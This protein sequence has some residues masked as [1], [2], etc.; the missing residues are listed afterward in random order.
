MAHLAAFAF[1]VSLAFSGFM[2][3]A[4]FLDQPE[5][6]SNH[7][8]PIPTAGGIGIMAGFGAGMLAL[9]LF[10]PAYADQRLL[11]SL[12]ALGLGAGL[13][14]L[15]DDIYD[16]N[17]KWKFV[18]IILLAGA[19]VFAV[20]PPMTFPVIVGDGLAIPTWLGFAGAI[21]WIFVV[22]NGVNFMDGANGLMAGSMAIAFI[23]LCLIAVLVGA[24]SAAL[25][26]FIMA[27]ALFGFLPYN[28]GNQAKIFSGDVGS[29]LVGFMFASVSLLLV[30]EAPN[31]QLL[32]VGP[33]LFLPFLTDILLTMFLRANR[34]ENLFAP[35]STHLYQRLIRKG[36]TH[37]SI[38]ILYGLATYFMAVITIA[39]LWFGL[40]KSLFFLAIWVCV[41]SV[42]YLL[43]HKKLS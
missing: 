7:A 30:A 17:A 43:I 27:A 32:Y 13:L 29:L 40:I 19:C 8:R 23:A 11:G 26:S 2:I 15:F 22:T 41:F 12:T 1:L 14:G 28:A 39:G 10:Y 25:V 38:S 37:L 24:S 20:G 42:I 21:L 5:G 36:K 4:G 33:M 18:A 35:H 31:F 16:V 6:R 34:H 3:Y 9:A